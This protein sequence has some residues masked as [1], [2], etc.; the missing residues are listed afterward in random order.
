MVSLQLTCYSISHDF[1]GFIEKH[2][3]EFY[4]LFYKIQTNI[5]FEKNK[6]LP[7]NGS[8]IHIILEKLHFS[9][10][11]QI[12]NPFIVFTSNL[13]THLNKLVRCLL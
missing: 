9:S 1:L 3:F 13:P 4:S 10:H 7:K 6:F 8:F 12:L 5:L 11:R 2:N